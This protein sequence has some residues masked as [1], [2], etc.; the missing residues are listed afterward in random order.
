[1]PGES[2]R[3]LGTEESDEDGN[4]IRNMTVEDDEEDEA[5]MSKNWD[6]FDDYHKFQMLEKSKQEK[7]KR[8]RELEKERKNLHKSLELEE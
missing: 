3:T 8:E 7:K 2:A 5:E 6:L 4:L 1:M